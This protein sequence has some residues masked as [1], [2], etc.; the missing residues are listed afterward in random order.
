MTTMSKR[1]AISE[2]VAVIQI[3]VHSVG[4]EPDQ[5]IIRVAPQVS[6]TTTVC[7]VPTKSKSGPC[8][9]DEVLAPSDCPSGLH[10]RLP[11]SPST[12]PPRSREVQFNKE[13]TKL[14]GYRGP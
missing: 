8:S 6:R 11:H 10:P 2:S 3:G 1:S 7:E 14:L 5:R 9:R 4:E 12:K 13:V